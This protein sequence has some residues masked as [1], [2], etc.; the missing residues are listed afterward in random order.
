MAGSSRF[1]DFH[2]ALTKAFGGDSARASDFLRR[3]D[4]LAVSDGRGAGGNSY[5]VVAVSGSSDRLTATSP[6]AVLNV[7]AQGS[8][9]ATA[10]KAT[11]TLTLTVT[12]TEGATDA[13]RTF[14]FA[15]PT[16]VVASGPTD[17]FTF[18]AGTGISLT[19]AT[20]DPKGVE[21]ACT[22]AIPGGAMS[23][24]LSGGNYSLVND[25]ATPGSSKYY[26][27][28]TGGT[29]GF[30]DLPS[31]DV[32]GPTGATVGGIA[33][34]ADTSGKVIEDSTVTL[35][36]IASDISEA[37]A[38][39]TWGGIGGTLSD[40]SDLQGELDNKADAG[41]VGSS[42][43]T[44]NTARLLGR[45]TGS[46]GA[47]EEIT[48]GTGLSLSGGELSATGGG[49]GGGEGPFS[50]AADFFR[51]TATNGS[52]DL[53]QLQTNAAHPNQMYLAFLPSVDSFAE[54]LIPRMP[55]G[56]NLG[57]VRFRFLWGHGATTTNF[58]VVWS[59]QARVTRDDDLV[60]DAFG[61]AVNVTD[62]GG[63]TNDYY[64]SDFTGSVTPSGT[65]AAN[66]AMWIRIARLGSHGSDTMA[67]N[68]RLFGVIMEWD[69][70]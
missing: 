2:A 21:I 20:S 46:S 41:G 42:G 29:K 27:T 54:C 14:R 9:T 44:M 13:F 18:T 60:A 58:D 57:A 68:A 48:V 62:T 26:G 31:G 65:A 59:V 36:G 17:T 70:A 7:L 19:P 12:G 11:G 47:I 50:I 39:A 67:V 38:T 66:C 32:T 37:A 51:P 5:G 53:Q 3:L 15:G 61:T 43:L 34:F 10:N 33:V 25:N 16:D 69:T 4:R 56:W 23:V 30:F 49:G 52:L 55:D 1:S 40:Q 22:L 63:T 28:D 45:T 24:Q 6:G 64:V 8:I 35:S